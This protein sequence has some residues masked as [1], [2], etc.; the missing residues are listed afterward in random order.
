MGWFRVEKMVE[1]GGLD[2]AYH[3]EERDR[4]AELELKIAMEANRDNSNPT[5]IHTND[6]SR[7]SS[8][9]RPKVVHFG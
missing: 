9:H 3:A 2:A 7:Q 8:S 4:V 6:S 1:I 5:R